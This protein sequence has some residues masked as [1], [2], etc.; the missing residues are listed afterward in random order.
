MVLYFQ[1]T[2]VYV[3]SILNMTA[4]HNVNF[5]KSDQ[6][7][8]DGSLL[9]PRNFRETLNHRPSTSI[10]FF[11]NAQKINYTG[12]GVYLENIIASLVYLPDRLSF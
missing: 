7:E 2:A 9:I 1:T 4:I 12:D 3:F 6:T 5:G 11:L 8:S 10:S